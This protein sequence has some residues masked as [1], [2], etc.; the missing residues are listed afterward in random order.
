MDGQSQNGY[1]R[2]K[3]FEPAGGLYTAQTRH[4]D[5]HQDDIKLVSL[6]QFDGFCSGTG[7]IYNFHI[8]LGA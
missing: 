5:I 4:S 7:L 3:S 2:T 8:R 1:V 6:G